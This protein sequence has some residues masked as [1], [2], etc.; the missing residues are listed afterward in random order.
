MVSN[1][2]NLCRSWQSVKPSG[3][4]VPAPFNL[5]D[6]AVC[7]ADPGS[8]KSSAFKTSFSVGIVP[9]R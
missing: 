9:N 7:C 1:Q 6:H 4:A 3:L 8:V 2:G 5:K